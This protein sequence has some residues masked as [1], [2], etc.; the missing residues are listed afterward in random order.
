MGFSWEKGADKGG[1]Q[2]GEATRAS[3]GPGK[4]TQVDRIPFHDQIQ[5][6]FGG[7]HDVSRIRAHHD[8]ESA[9]AVGAEA[10]ATG[11]EV[12]FGREPSL[13][14]AAH[15]A[16]HVVQQRQGISMYGG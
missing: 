12:V 11:E 7:A 4:R 6:S 2:T 9:A 13:H 15:E 1:P 3:A 5:S 10:Y 14:V 8:P 16:A